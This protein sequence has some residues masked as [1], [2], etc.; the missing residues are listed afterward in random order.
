MGHTAYSLGQCPECSSFELGII[1]PSYGRTIREQNRLALHYYRKYHCYYKMDTSR[2][3]EEGFSANRFC[4]ACGFEW[5]AKG[6]G[7]KRFSKLT[8]QNE[9][10]LHHFLKSNCYSDDT[11]FYA[12][13]RN[14]KYIPKKE[15]WYCKIGNY[16][17]KTYL[18]RF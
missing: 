11:E 16:I 8:F 7:K 18:S 17:K 5:Y 3:W 13:H 14:A 12:V 15:K 4:V 10:M 1:E 2:D 9:E 6:K